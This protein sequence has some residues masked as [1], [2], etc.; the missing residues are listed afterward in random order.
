MNGTTQLEMLKMVNAIRR[1][2]P[3]VKRVGR[4]WENHKKICTLCRDGSNELWEAFSDHLKTFFP[5]GNTTRPQP[6]NGEIWQINLNKG[7]WFRQVYLS[8]PA[9]LV[10][11][12]MG[13]RAECLVVYP[14]KEPAAPG[15]LL[16]DD[17]ETGFVEMMVE[18]WNRI[19]VK[20]DDL[21]VRLGV[22]SKNY[23]HDIKRYQ[24][25][26]NF[27]P[28]WAEVPR[29]IKHENDPRNAFKK[30]E[31][32]TA[33]HFSMKP[34]DVLYQKAEQFIE[35]FRKTSLR[36]NALSLADNVTETLF[37]F[38]F[39]ETTIPAVA[40]ASS[41]KH[42][43]AD[44]RTVL[45]KGNGVVDFFPSKATIESDEIENGIRT[46]LGK[47]E[48]QKNH[49]LLILTSCLLSDRSMLEADFSDMDDEG[50]FMVK[51]EISGLLKDEERM[52][53]SFCA[54]YEQSDEH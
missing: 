30:I 25:D 12:I 9:V 7:R 52:T 8:P 44:F 20:I 39:P 53:P 5:N 1:C 28:D 47:S 46:I 4:K 34:I 35:A 45:M 23:L 2:P 6:E 14:D 27:I 54:I 38:K 32:I 42:L 43:P 51:F 13:K 18:T 40:A 19:W 41:D 33:L 36:T 3:P 31:K 29:S 10:I 37:R 16:L 26:M 17:E 22:I 49:T 50:N 24:E 15:D 21:D 11:D 48:I